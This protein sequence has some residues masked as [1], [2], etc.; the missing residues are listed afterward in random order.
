[1]AK[2]TKH[3]LINKKIPNINHPVIKVGNLIQIPP[4]IPFV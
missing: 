4:L 1:L 3:S 2:K